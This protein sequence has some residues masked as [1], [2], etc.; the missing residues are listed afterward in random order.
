MKRRGKQVST[1]LCSDWGPVALSSSSAFPELGGS[2]G[3]GGGCSLKACKHCLKGG[4]ESRQSERALYSFSHQ[5]SKN[6]VSKGVVFLL[7]DNLEDTL[8]TFLFSI[9]THYRR[10]IM[11]LFKSFLEKLLFSVVLSKDV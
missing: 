3:S 9:L 6:T 7:E 8:Q 11:R 5:G 2:R 10:G 1:A 4:G